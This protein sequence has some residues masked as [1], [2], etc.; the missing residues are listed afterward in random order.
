MEQAAPIWG[1]G[2]VS[3][4]VYERANIVRARERALQVL[5]PYLRKGK[6]ME[7][8]QNFQS[9]EVNLDSYGISHLFHQPAG[10]IK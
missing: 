8:L 2:L 9:K 6:G 4:I 7:N 1:K 10:R 3:A 5:L